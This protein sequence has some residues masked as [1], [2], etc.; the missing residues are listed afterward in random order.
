MVASGVTG[1]YTILNMNRERTMNGTNDSA[2]LCR[3]DTSD[4]PDAID[5][6]KEN[7]EYERR[8]KLVE[9]AK[10]RIFKA[11]KV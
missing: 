10:K 3:N 9:E 4:R 7:K 2:G 1:C 6:R 5:L 8:R 11:Q